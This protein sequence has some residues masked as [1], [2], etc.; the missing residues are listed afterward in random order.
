MSSIGWANVVF[1]AAALILPISALAAHRMN[2][3][4]GLRYVLIWASVFAAM[5]LLIR[6]IS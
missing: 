2:W 4:T 3:K 5:T 6:A 1:V